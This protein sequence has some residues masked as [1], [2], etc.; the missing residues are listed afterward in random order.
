MDAQITPGRYLQ[1]DSSIDFFTLNCRTFSNSCITALHE[2]MS[3]LV[4]YKAVCSN[5]LT[6]YMDNVM[7]TRMCFSHKSLMQYAVG[8]RPTHIS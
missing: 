2:I 4:L 6:S 3:I 8:L 1:R 5:V 7:N